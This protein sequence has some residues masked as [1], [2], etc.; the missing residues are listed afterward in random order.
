MRKYLASFAQYSL[1]LCFFICST[2]TANYFNRTIASFT[3]PS[4]E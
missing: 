2:N 1:I 3:K 4:D